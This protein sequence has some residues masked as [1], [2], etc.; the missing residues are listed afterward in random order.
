MEEEPPHPRAELLMAIAGPIASF[1]LAWL[2]WALESLAAAAGWPT[3]IVGVCHTIGLI[4]LT[5]AI[6]NLVPAFPL[7]GGRVLRAIL[8]HRQKDLRAATEV[9]ARTGR[10]FGMVLIVL[11]LLR[12]FE[13]SA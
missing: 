10:A 11:Q 12:L 6:F 3:A 8:W 7:D 9:A 5:V 1:C 2:F 4:N 13:Q